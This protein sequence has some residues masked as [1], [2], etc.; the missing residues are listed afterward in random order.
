MP[1][2][3]R[4]DALVAAAAPERQHHRPQEPPSSALGERHGGRAVLELPAGLE[5]ERAPGGKLR[6]TACPWRSAS[7]PIRA[8]S[9]AGGERQRRRTTHRPRSDSG[10]PSRSSTGMSSV[11]APTRRGVSEALGGAANTCSARSAA[12]AARVSRSCRRSDH[13]PERRRGIGRPR[14]DPEL[15]RREQLATLARSY[16]QLISVRIDSPS[17][18]V[19]HA[20]AGNRHRLIARSTRDASRCGGRRAS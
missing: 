2:A 3:S 20:D 6:S 7:P 14:L 10:A 15:G 5:G 9:V 16:L 1:T 17:A 11:S 4:R 18:N 19:H 13:Q 8:G 12:S